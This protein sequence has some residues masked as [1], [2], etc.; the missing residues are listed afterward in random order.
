V[1]RRGGYRLRLLHAG[2]TLRE[3]LELVGLDDALPPADRKRCAAD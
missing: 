1:A 2:R 3:L